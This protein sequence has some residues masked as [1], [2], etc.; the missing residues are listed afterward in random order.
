MKSFKRFFFE[1]TLDSINSIILK[2]AS[3]DSDEEKNVTFTGNDAKEKALDY[4]DEW[5]GLDGG[6]NYELNYIKSRDGVMMIAVHGITL[7]ELLHGNTVKPPKDY[8]YNLSD[9][10]LK[11][12]LPEIYSS[13]EKEDSYIAGGMEFRLSQVNENKS[14]TRKDPRAHLPKR[15]NDIYRFEPKKENEDIK[16][17]VVFSGSLSETES[18]LIHFY[19]TLYKRPIVIKDGRKSWLSAFDVSPYRVDIFQKTLHFPYNQNEEE[20]FNKLDEIFKE[21]KR[22]VLANINPSN[23][24]TI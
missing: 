5:V 2:R 13:I 4:I 6:K 19:I 22:D 10:L 15:N 23:Q 16:E 11:L 12:N 9:I 18:G 21:I 1:N 3:I 7:R 24:L 8:L 20:T 14:F 17:E